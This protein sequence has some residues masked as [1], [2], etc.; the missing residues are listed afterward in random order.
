MP[1]GAVRAHGSLKPQR[2]L[3]APPLQRR[4]WYLL[5]VDGPLAHVHLLQYRVPDPQLRD[6]RATGRQ[7]KLALSL[8][9]RLL[10]LL[11]AA[12]QA[13]SCAAAWG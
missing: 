3:R 8:P 12:Q 4:M 11:L 10:R 7:G 1:Q 9:M 6:K 5:D 2:T 13:Q